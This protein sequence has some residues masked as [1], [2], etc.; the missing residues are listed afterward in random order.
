MLLNRIMEKETFKLVSCEDRI[1]EKEKN[2]NFLKIID[3][4]RGFI[5]DWFDNLNYAKFLKTPLTLSMFVPCG[6][7]GSVLTETWKSSYIDYNNPPPDDYMLEGRIAYDEALENVLFD[8]F[9]VELIE[10]YYLVKRDGGHVWTSRHNNTTI[11]D[12]THID[13]QVNTKAYNNIINNQ[14][15]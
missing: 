3:E 9:E 7:D 6:E 11:S 14:F 13:M 8:G 2:E 4:E 5:K 10:N 1:I 15:V 12:L